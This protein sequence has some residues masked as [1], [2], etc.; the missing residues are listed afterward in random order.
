MTQSNHRAPVRAGGVDWSG[1]R[2]RVDVA[3]V[4][5][6]L[7]GEPPGRR[8]HNGARLWWRCPFHEDRNPSMAV[9]PGSSR[10]FCFGCRAG[11]DAVG[12]VMKSRRCSFREAVV[13]I[14]NELGLVGVGGRGAATPPRPRAPE[15]RPDDDRLHREAAELVA[16]ASERLW[17]T[18]GS[19]ALRELHARGLNAQTIQVARLGYASD[20]RMIGRGRR[21]YEGIVIP[22][23]GP[24]GVELIK[25]RQLD[26]GEPRYVELYRRRPILY[27]GH[28]LARLPYHGDVVIVEGEL[29]ALLLGQELESLAMVVT[30][31]SASSRPSSMTRMAVDLAYRLFAATDNDEAGDRAASAWPPRAK[32]V[33][34]PSDHKD[35][36]DAHRAGVDLRRWWT[37]HL[38]TDPIDVEERPRGLPPERLVTLAKGETL[39]AAGLAIG[40][41]YPDPEP[42]F[43]DVPPP[44]PNRR[45]D[46]EMG[47]E[48]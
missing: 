34:P 15:V 27:P 47:F 41:W 1:L 43:Q 44:P 11:G 10:W 19:G 33:R 40:P 8:G 38:V 12:L 21:R 39:R 6:R 48:E 26:G 30:T 31:G 24:G 25:L 28:E 5:R 36:T 18:D 2:D 46:G 23:M 13:W 16:R 7:L 14:G 3:E 37:Q 20:A 35:W 17:T 22:W 9:E 32:R 29:D 4:A 42:T 45:P